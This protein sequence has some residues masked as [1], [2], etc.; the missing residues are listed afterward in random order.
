MIFSENQFARFEI[1]LG[2]DAEQNDSDDA[3]A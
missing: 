2:R 3:L 1:M